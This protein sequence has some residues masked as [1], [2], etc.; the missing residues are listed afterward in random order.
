MQRIC[1]LLHVS[2]G[3]EGVPAW[4]TGTAAWKLLSLQLQLL[5]LSMLHADGK[6]KGVGRERHWPC[7]DSFQALD[8]G[9][10][11]GGRADTGKGG[12]QTEVKVECCRQQGF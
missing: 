8:Q 1:I 7:S 4:T 3:T 9:L 10:A 5:S 12:M 11:N 2:P 6:T